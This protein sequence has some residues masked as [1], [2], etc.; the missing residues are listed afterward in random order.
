HAHTETFQRP[1]ESLKKCFS[2]RSHQLRSSGGGWSARIGNKVC[3]GEVNFMPNARDDRYRGSANGTRHALV[4]ERPQILERATSAGHYQHVALGSSGRELD[5]RYQARD[6]CI[7]LDW[8]RVDE[9]RCGRIPSGEDVQDVADGSARR[10]GD[11][12]Y[13]ARKT[14]QAAL[15]LDG[16]QALRCELYLEA[17]ELASE[18]SDAGFFEVLDDKLKF[19]AGLVQGDAAAGEDLLPNLR[20]ESQG[21]ISLTK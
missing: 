12:P 15:P 3:D 10:R 8:S 19:A 2:I 7:T 4:V 14:G 20:R 11:Y 18:R 17:F 5:G 21:H 6:G 16:E 9:H 13:A 1:N